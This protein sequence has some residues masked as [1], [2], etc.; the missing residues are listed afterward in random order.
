[1]TKAETIKLVLRLPPEMHRKLVRSAD[2]QRRS[3]NSEILARLDHSLV[4]AGSIEGLMD[5]FRSMRHDSEYVRTI[6]R[7]LRR[8][9]REMKGG[10]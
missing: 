7:V 9:I 10:K 3:L 6:D 4:D 5:E 2:S 8:I 1:M